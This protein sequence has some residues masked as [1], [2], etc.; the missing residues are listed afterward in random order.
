MANKR[1][2]MVSSNL[3]TPTTYMLGAVQVARSSRE[4][5]LVCVPGKRL[6]SAPGFNDD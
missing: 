3:P 4:N 6:D 1:Q 5:P 2:G